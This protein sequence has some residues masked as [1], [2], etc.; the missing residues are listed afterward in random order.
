MCLLDVFILEWLK[1][2]PW[3]SAEIRHIKMGVNMNS[4]KTTFS[5]PTDMTLRNALSQLLPDK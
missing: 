2:L 3:R 1:W 5:F 4:A